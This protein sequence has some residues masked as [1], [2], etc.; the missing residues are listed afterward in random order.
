MRE[1]PFGRG[2]E[3][4]VK[5]CG[6]T[7]WAD[8]R[9]AVAAGADALGFNFHPPSPRYIEPR[10]AAQ[11][12]RRLPKRVV[13]V[14]VFVDAPVDEIRR[15]AD[16]VGLDAVQLHGGERPGRVRQAAAF[17]ATIKAFRVRPG[18]PIARLKAFPDAAAFLLDG[19]RPG[20]HGGTGTRFD[21]C[22]VRQAAR[23]GPVILAGGLRAE[24]VA[25][26]IS[27]AR[28]YAVDVSS[29]VEARPGKKDAVKVREFLR[30]VRRVRR[31]RR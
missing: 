5:I 26:A 22:L 6:I 11:I 25:E 16:A 27:R 2:P 30:Q 12:A 20:V 1:L 7:C 13:K 29:G 4:R 24:N 3:P 10:K 18:F 9:A 14:G 31:K 21:W 28:P 19:Y 15:I 23:Y 17:R 8:A